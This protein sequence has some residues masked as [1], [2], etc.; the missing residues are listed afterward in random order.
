MDLELGLSSLS[1]AISE[2]TAQRRSQW[3]DATG[4]EFETRFMRPLA[5]VVGEF[6]CAA[7][8][9]ANV[10]DSAFAELEH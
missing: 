1:T 6:H 9:Y 8:D 4:L 2:L 3:P 7:I 10:V 5:E